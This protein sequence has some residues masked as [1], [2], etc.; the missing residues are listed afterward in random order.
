MH[1]LNFQFIKKTDVKLSYISF[2][3]QQK[4]NYFLILD[5]RLKIGLF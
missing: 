1:S 5:F 4:T 2:L 3:K